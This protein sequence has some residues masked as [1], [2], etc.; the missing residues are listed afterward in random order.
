ML[1]CVCIR[2]KIPEI[3]YDSSLSALYTA[4]MDQDQE[5]SDAWSTFIIQEP[6]MFAETLFSL[7][8]D[9]GAGSSNRAALPMQAAASAVPSNEVAGDPEL[10]NIGMVEDFEFFDLDNIDFDLSA[11]ATEPMETTYSSD[12]AGGE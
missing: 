11:I 1:Q 8:P 10:S 9:G 4:L 3:H 12:F 6:D 2:S 5:M 7:S